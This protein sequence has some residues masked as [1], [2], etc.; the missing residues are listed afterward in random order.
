MRL[1]YRTCFHTLYD[2][3]KKYIYIYKVSNV[4]DNSQGQPEGYFFVCYYTTIPFSGLLHFT[5]DPFL[6]MLSVKQGA[7][8]YHFWAFGKAWPGIESWPTKPLVNT[9]PTKPMG[10]CIYTYIY[11]C[12]HAHTQRKELEIIQFEII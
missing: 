8:K 4:G 1:G 2:E 3:K 11:T 12:T 6:I 9:L 7:I 10:Q 5:L